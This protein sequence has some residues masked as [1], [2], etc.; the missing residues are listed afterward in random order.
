[1][2]LEN[3]VVRPRCFADQVELTETATS[4]AARTAAGYK[5]TGD[6]IT[7][8]YTEKE[9]I[10]NLSATTTVNINP[11]AVFTYYGNMKLTPELD[12][13]KDTKTSPDLVV[14][15]DLLYNNIKDIPNPAHKIGSTWN[16]WQNNWTGAFK[17]KTT[18]GNT[19]TTKKGRTGTAT[20]TGIKREL[21]SQVVNQSF[22]ERL[23]DLSYIPYIRSKTISFTITGLKPLTNHYAF[24]EEVGIDSYITPTGGSLGAQ[25]ISDANGSLSGTFAIP[26]PSVSGNPKW[27]CGERLFKV[28]DSQTSDAT[29][30][31]NQSFAS[32]KYRAQG[33]LVTEQETVY[34]TRVPDVVGTKI[35]QHKSIRK[36]TSTSTHTIRPTSPR[37]DRGGGGGQGGG[38][39]G[40]RNPPSNGN[41]PGHHPGGGGYQGGS[42]GSSG[43]FLAGTLV[44]MANGTQKPIE[45]IDIGD[46]VLVG[47]SIFATGKFLINNLFDYNGIKVS[48]SHMVKENGTWMRVSDSK[49]AKSLGDDKHIVYIFG[50][51]NR[52]LKI[53]DILFTDYFEL[54]EQ[55]KLLSSKDSYFENWKEE[56][57]K[58]DK[59]EAERNVK[60]MNEQYGA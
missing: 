2:D 4:D 15:N 57:S 33:L 6:L 18:R 59:I 1:M 45:Q 50:S 55:E 49:Q 20:R 27:R 23:V 11:F 48:G 41:R 51:E 52:R 39:G 24:F 10:S 5:K 29:S 46:N 30:E 12:E 58:I 37:S 7:L 26:D 43:C 8:P 56:A 17:E 47:G 32:A 9:V 14:N 16:E 19:T 25:L 31:F 35:L 36:V 42:G 34:A 40:H 54:T 3:G 21:S 53:N 44:Q 28:S 13:W 60:F 38:G 22:G